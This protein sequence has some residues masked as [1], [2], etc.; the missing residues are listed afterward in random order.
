LHTVKVLSYFAL[1][2]TLGTW[3]NIVNKRVL[4]RLPLPWTVASAQ[5][6]IGGVWVA[7][8]WL[9]RLRAAPSLGPYDLASVLP[10]AVFHGGGQLATVL[11]LG[12]GAVSFT[13]IVKAM[14]PF[15]SAVV[16]AVCFRQVFRPQVYA[17]LIPVVAGVSVACYSELTFSWFSFAA[18]MI[19]NLFFAL[20]ANFSKAIMA[21]KPRA[22]PAAATAAS[23]TTAGTAAAAEPRSMSPAN[24]YAV[25]TM[26]AFALT[27]PIALLAEG[28][29]W[30]PAWAAARA[31]GAPAQALAMSVLLSGLTH[32]LNN[33]V[34]YLALNNVHPITL[35][36][37]NTMKRVFIIAASLI[38][39][40]NPISQLG[41]IGSAI[42]IGGVLLYSLARNYYG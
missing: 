15:F 19:S 24:L 42:G 37:G 35:A 14:E 7:V 30:G 4:N 28:S 6:G 36:V 39:F 20:R 8:Q 11:S 31:G 38:V 12:A 25:V 21:R 5:L 34:M 23:A 40:R 16:S 41:A 22:A 33:E 26:T 9:L 18:A 1:W 10:V 29:K 27:A 3:Y 13:H 2:F 17:A 32:Y